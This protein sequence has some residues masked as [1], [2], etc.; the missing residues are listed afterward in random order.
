MFAGTVSQRGNKCAQTF[1]TDYGWSRA[2]PMKSKGMAHEAL[3]TVFR[4]Y[5]VPPS[6]VTDGAKELR[7]GVWATKCRDAGCW[8][9]HKGH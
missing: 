4:R 7:L 9:S 2:F 1:C 8:L 3:T 6:V 5:G